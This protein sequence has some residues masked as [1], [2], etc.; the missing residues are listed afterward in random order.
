M[1]RIDYIF[2]ILFLAMGPLRAI[3]VFH[4]LTHDNDWKYR[5]RAA[6]F[7]ILIAGA[8]FALVVATGVSTVR[9]W[10]VSPAAL[11]IAIG[12]LLI[13][14][15]FVTLT[16]LN[17]ANLKPVE[18]V[19]SPRKVPSAEA[20][21]FSP[22]AAPTI[23]TPTGVVT[24]VLFLFLARGDTVLEQQIYLVLAAMLLL[25]FACMMAAEFIMRFVRLELLAVIGWVFAALQSA[26]AIEVILRG[27]KTAGL[28]LR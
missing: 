25:N 28:G 22:L 19:A 11:E 23:V 20:L 3:P 2:T 27:L 18:T 4:E 26:L 5:F 15:T 1:L 10:E 14:S 9:S 21:A 13:R 6:L 16:M 12:I 7:A 24:I 17:P 8:I